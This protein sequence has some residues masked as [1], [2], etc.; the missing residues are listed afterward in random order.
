M[1]HSTPTVALE[2]L[3]NLTPLH[4]LIETESTSV[5]YRISREASCSIRNSGHSHIY[6]K[7]KDY[8]PLIQANKDAIKPV[9]KF[10]RKFQLIVPNR[11]DWNTNLYPTDDLSFYTDGSLKNGLAGAGIFNETYNIEQ[12]IPLAEMLPS[13][14]RS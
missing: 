2:T 12:S 4:I 1:W 10:E 14:K 6:F 7:A 5:L 11:N 3:L 9:F 8:L 13:I